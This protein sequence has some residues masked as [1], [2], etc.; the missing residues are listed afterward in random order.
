M[1]R[2]D[3]LRYIKNTAGGAT[4]ADFKEDWRPV[5]DM[6]WGL[7]VRDNLVE[8]RDGKIFLTDKGGQRLIE[9]EEKQL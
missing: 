8:E 6:E 2:I 4:A 5:G 9:L 3:S 1:R 7:L